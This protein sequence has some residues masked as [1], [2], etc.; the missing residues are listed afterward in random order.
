MLAKPGNLGEREDRWDS[1]FSHA[2]HF[3]RALMPVIMFA[4]FCT[5][6]VS[7]RPAPGFCSR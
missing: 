3:Q 2:A 6:A 1:G 5:G 4:Y 7:A